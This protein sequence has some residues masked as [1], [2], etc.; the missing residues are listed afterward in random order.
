M[1]ITQSTIS[2]QN[3]ERAC[4]AK[5]KQRCYNPNDA[6]YKDYGGRGIRVC[7]GWSTFQQF[8]EDTGGRPTPQHSLDR[9]DNNGHYS[10][11]KCAEC[12]ENGWPKNWRWATPLE[13]SNNTRRNVR[14]TKHGKTL[15]ITQW[16]KELGVSYGTLCSRR[17]RGLPLEEVLAPVK[18]RRVLTRKPRRRE[19]GECTQ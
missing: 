1:P 9:P 17:S 14:I 16:A 4:Y 2:R 13:Q 12:I 11:G 18:Q 3:A 5:M 10:C 15:T 19:G 6:A 8:S 7:A